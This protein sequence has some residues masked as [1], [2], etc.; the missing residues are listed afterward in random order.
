MYKDD[1]NFPNED[2]CLFKN[3]PYENY[4]ILFVSGQC[5]DSCTYNYYMIR[6]QTLL[7][8]CSRLAQVS[9]MFLFLL[10]GL[11]YQLILTVLYS[12]NF[13]RRGFKF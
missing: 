2:F 11:F 3:F 6:Y 10:S 12:E 13:P 1:Y 5:F 7:E 9:F 4:L 8:T